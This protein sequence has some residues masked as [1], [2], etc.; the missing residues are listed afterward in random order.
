LVKIYMFFP[1]VAFAAAFAPGLRG[2]T[3]TGHRAPAA[4]MVDIPR[5]ELPTSLTSVLKEQDLKNPNEL[6]VNEYNSYSAA[7]IGGTL[8]LLLPGFLVFDITGAVADFVLSAVIGGGLGAFLA[9]GST[10]AADLANK[11]G[12]KVLDVAGVDIPRIELPDAVTSALKDIDLK[13]PNDLGTTDYNNYSGAAIAGTLALFLPGI[14]VFDIT[15]LVADFVLSATIG[16]GLAAYLA[17]RSDGAGDF[18]NKAGA[19]LLS[20]VDKVAGD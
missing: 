15:G 9:L 17:L 6:A 2:V 5:I 16:G 14:L 12:A 4:R 13:N 11:A 10:G 20:A 3:Y 1:V 8:A 18:A 7:A 19:A